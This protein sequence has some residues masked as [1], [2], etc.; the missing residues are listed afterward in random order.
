MLV[1]A[2]GGEEGALDALVGVGGV[3]GAEA[4][5]AA[6][7]GVVVVAVAFDAVAPAGAAAG[8][9]EPEEARGP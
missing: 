2:R 1:V 4:L 7:A 9:E 6:A 8:A 5:F 3:F